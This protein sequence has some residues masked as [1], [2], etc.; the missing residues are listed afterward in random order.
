[1]RVECRILNSEFLGFPAFQPA[2]DLQFDTL[3]FKTPSFF[4]LS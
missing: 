4:W 3:L 2:V 1:M